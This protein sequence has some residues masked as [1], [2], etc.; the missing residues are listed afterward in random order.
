MRKT[1][2]LCRTSPVLNFL[3]LCQKGKHQIEEF[4]QRLTIYL[5]RAKRRG[6]EKA[7]V[8]VKRKERKL[9]RKD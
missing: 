8:E 7:E 4:F 9:L 3:E 5:K 1:E 6:L 2:F